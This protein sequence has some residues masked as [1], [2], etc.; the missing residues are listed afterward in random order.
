MEEW[1]QHIKEVRKVSLAADDIIIIRS[2]ELLSD[3]VGDRIKLEVKKTFPDNE[4]LLFDGG[5]QLDIITKKM[6]EDFEEDDREGL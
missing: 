1:Q 5:L 2:D 3:D 6:I 4:V